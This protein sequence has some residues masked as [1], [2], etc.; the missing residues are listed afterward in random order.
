[1]PGTGDVRAHTCALRMLRCRVS[2]QRKD[3]RQ[4]HKPLTNKR[5]NSQERDLIWD[6]ASPPGSLSGPARTPACDRTG[7]PLTSLSSPFALLPPGRVGSVGDPGNAHTSAHR[8]PPPLSDA[9]PSP[10]NWPPCF[11]SCPSPV[12]TPQP[13]GLKSPPKALQPL[14]LALNNKTH[15]PRGP[16]GAGFHG[17]F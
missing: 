8:E 15:G 6:S 10:S 2:Q 17:P 5:P 4:A 14:P 13:S 16:S 3:Q 12:S 1:M 9:Q 11:R 7:L